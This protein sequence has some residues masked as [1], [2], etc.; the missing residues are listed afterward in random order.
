MKLNKILFASHNAGKIAE[1]KNYSKMIEYEFLQLV[2]RIKNKITFPIG[3]AFVG[4]LIEK[5][6]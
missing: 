5:K 6:F 1:I 3:K 2:E 4:Y